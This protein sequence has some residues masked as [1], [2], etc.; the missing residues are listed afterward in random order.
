MP[1][2]RPSRIRTGTRD[3]R[4]AGMGKGMIA[5][6]AGAAALLAWAPAAMARVF[7]TVEV[8]GAEF[9]PE[10]DIQLTCGAAAGIDYYDIELQAIQ[11]CLMSTGVF[12]SVAV[13][14]ENGT[15]VIEVEEVELRPGRVEGS[16][17]WD[18]ED[19]LTLGFSFERYNLFPNTFGS[20]YVDVARQAYRY[21]GSLYRADAFGPT[22]DLG[23]DIVG[24]GTDYDD[25][26]YDQDSLRGAP[27]IAWT[28]NDTTRFEFA[29][30]YRDHRMDDID[31]GA[32]P[33]LFQEEGA[34]AGAYVRLGFDYSIG[35]DAVEGAPVPPGYAIGIDQY[36]WNLGTSDTLSDTRIE[37][38]TRLALSPTLR[39]LLG[40]TGGGVQGLD[41][42]ATRAMDRFYPGAD[43][44]RGFAPRGI[45]P[46]DN[47]DALGANSYLVG[48]IELQ[49]DFAEV[50]N[51]T[52]RGGL[53]FD[54]GSAW[55]LDDT[56]NGRI[57]DSAHLRSSVGISIS[58]DI[59]GTPASFYIA[60]P[61][62]DQPGDDTQ[63]FGLSVAATF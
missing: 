5:G 10:R 15:M 25:L 17:M 50:L 45:G 47:G 14:G 31:A 20:L 11:E 33:L 59:A 44:F 19:Y 42:N 63:I 38:D 22:L 2:Q 1:Q 39:L 28:P 60:Q 61:I 30:G 58:F 27:F 12:E 35:G 48:S 16:I 54:V 57:D 7:D 53:F 29:L 43:T 32:S 40:L 4:A 51:R 21:G 52:V 49:R 62:Q 37:A 26:A 55:G 9:V 41:G 23:L 6:A 8:R 56:L 13:Y 3:R 18:S 34:V 46:R 24:F 36:F